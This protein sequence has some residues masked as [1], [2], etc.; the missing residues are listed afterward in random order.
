MTK[1][2]AKERIRKL[3]SLI[4]HHQHLYHTLDA[5]EISDASFDT[6]VHKLTDLEKDFPELATPDSPSQRIG[7]RPLKQFQ[8]VQHISRMYS[9]NDAFLQ[10]DVQKWLT[11]LANLGIKNIPEFYCDLKMDGLA[12]ELK[13]VNGIFV[14]GSTRGDG[15]VGEDI[16]QNIKTIEVIPLKLK[17]GVSG[18]I[19]IRGEVFLTKKE[20]ARI[21]KEQEKRAE[22]YM[23]IHEI[24]PLVLSVSLIQKLPHLENLIFTPMILLVLTTHSKQKKKNITN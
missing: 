3:R 5:P 6:L 20:F 10:E 21:N 24:P 14:Q 17:G 9:L 2:E 4:S 18:E 8:K 16:T 7:G 23:P 22:R 13:Y 12:V 19:Y 1:S 15:L 11:R